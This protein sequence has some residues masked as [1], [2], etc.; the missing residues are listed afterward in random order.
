MGRANSN[1]VVFRKAN[2]AVK[3]SAVRQTSVEGKF[4]KIKS[5]I[6]ISEYYEERRRKFVIDIM[7]APADDPIKT[8]CIDNEL[9][10]LEHDGKRVG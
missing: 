4:K 9:H 10:L 3:T 6:P 5:I 2:E 7:G 1:A 8:V